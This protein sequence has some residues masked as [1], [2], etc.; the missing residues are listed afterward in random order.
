[1]AVGTGLGNYTIS[2]HAG[3]LTV[4]KANTGASVSSSSDPSTSGH[5]VTFT[6]TVTGTGATGTVTFKDGETTLGSSTLSNG[7]ATYTTSTV[8][9]GSHSITAVY[10]GDANFA[11]ST[12]SAVDPTVKPAVG[13]RWGLIAWILPAA[14]VVGLFFLLVISRRRR[15]RSAGANVIS[16]DV[17][18]TI[19]DAG[20]THG[21]ADPVVTY[22]ISSG[23]L[24]AG[25]AFTGAIARVAGEG[26]GTYAIQ[27]GTLALNSNYNLTFVPGTFTIGIRRK[28]SAGPNVIS[29]RKRPAGAN[30]TPATR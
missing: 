30:R 18:V 15:K 11:G 24:A 22:H 19:D 29:K 26:V 16:R 13:L 9:V 21:D 28:R 14:A 20:K 17:E 27:Q 1:V 2:Y 3:S 23:S 8:S 25:D 4:N 10:G 5:S 12:S 6:A 7:T